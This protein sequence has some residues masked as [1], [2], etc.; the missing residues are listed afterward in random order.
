MHDYIKLGMMK[1]EF[2]E[3]CRA[4]DARAAQASKSTMSS[5]FASLLAGDIVE[6]DRLCDSLLDIDDVKK[7]A[8]I[9]VW[10]QIGERHGI[11]R[12]EAERMLDSKWLVH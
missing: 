6:R 9:E 5:A 2:E 3:A 1:A 4:I 10:L 12:K 7:R 11:P 8:K